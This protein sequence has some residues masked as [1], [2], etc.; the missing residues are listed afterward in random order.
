MTMEWNTRLL[1]LVDGTCINCLHGTYIDERSTDI[2]ERSADI[3]DSSAD[4]GEHGTDIYRR[5]AD[6]RDASTAR[7]PTL[8]L[9]HEALGCLAMWKQFPQRLAERTGCDVFLYERRGYG[10]ST[11]ITLPRPDTYLVDEGRDWL[12]PILDAAGL[13][14]V[15]LIGHSDGGSVALVGAATCADRVRGLVTMAAH[16][17]VDHL[18]SAGIEEAVHRYHNTDLSRRLERYLGG[19]TET[20]F[21]AWYETW[22][23]PSFRAG[24]DL[25]PWLADIRCP[26]LIM[27][28]RD[29]QYGV[30]SQVTDICAGIGSHAQPLLLDDCGHVPHLEAEAATLAAID[31]FLRPVL[32][33]L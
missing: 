26:A 12:R 9:L 27:Q 14:Q 8:V 25:T 31:Q 23:R 2:G 7:R 20:I 6:A 16:I 13:E 15:V 18:T 11:P 19:R 32:L 17:Y 30:A 28:G 3:C 1:T 21:R 29:D 22:Q 5:N 4:I 33:S 10:A 24:L